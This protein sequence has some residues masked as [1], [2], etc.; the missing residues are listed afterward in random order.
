MLLPYY[1]ISFV[2]KLFIFFFVSHNCVTVTV[3]GIMPLSHLMTCMTITYN[4]ILYPLSKSKIKKS[5]MK[6][7]IK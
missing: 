5:K 3:T 2:L 7:N 1:I 6:P 4:I